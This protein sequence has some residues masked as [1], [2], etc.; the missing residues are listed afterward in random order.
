MVERR[1]HVGREPPG[2]A[3]H[4]RHRVPVEIAKQVDGFVQAGDVAERE[5]NVVHG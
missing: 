4:G 3:D 1:D 5:Q 2:L